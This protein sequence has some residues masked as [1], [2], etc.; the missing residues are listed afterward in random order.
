LSPEERSEIARQ[1]AAARW[2]TPA[3]SNL[4][5]ATY[6]SPDRPLR[7]SNMEIP[8]YVLDDGRRVLVQRGMVTALGMARGS[9]AGTGGDRL[10]KFTAGKAL[11]PFV[12]E[13]LSTVTTRPIRFRTGGGVI[14]YGYEATVLADICEAVLAARKA[15][16]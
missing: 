13:H 10:A 11:E 4:P 7:I 2:G 1:A 6:G 15:N 8:C 3:P 16:R 5:L 12:S 14:A 9:S